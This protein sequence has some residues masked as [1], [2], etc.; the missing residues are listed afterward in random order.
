MLECK[1]KT[2][3]DLRKDQLMMKILGYAFVFMICNIVFSFTIYDKNNVELSSDKLVDEA[4]EVILRC[5]SAPTSPPMPKPVFI[6]DFKKG[7]DAGLN[8]DLSKTVVD[9]IDYQSNSDSSDVSTGIGLSNE[10][11]KDEII[12]DFNDLVD[13]PTFIG[14]SSQLSEFLETNMVYPKE[15]FENE[16]EGVVMVYFV[17]NKDG[18]I[19]DITVGEGNKDL[20]REA[21]RI[22]QKT[23]GKWQS[24]LIKGRPIRVRAKMPITFTI[25]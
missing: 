24:G 3:L 4:T 10:D 22:I 6:N 17:I 12:Y 21:V 1:K 15:P 9:S 7:F 8:T 5:P 11:I 20:Q 16:I 25:N 14:G 2:Q 18:T 19:S 23:S 13:L